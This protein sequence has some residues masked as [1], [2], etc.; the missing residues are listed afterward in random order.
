MRT[1]RHPGTP[2]A[3]RRH[4]AVPC[5]V[6]HHQDA[7]R[8]GT[9]LLQ[10]FD[11]LARQHAAHSAVARLQGGILSSMAYVMPALS[12]TPEHAV[13]YSDRHESARPVHLQTASV[14]L[15]RRN[16]EA[17]LHCHALWRDHTGRLAGGHLLAD[18]VIVHESPTAS[19][20]FMDGADFDVQ[21][22]TETNF[23]LFTPVRSAD[24]AFGKPAVPG[25]DTRRP[26]LAVS[27]RPNEDVCHALAAVCHEHGIERAH[28]H[29]GVGSLVGARLE[30]DVVVDPFV[31]EVLIED[32]HVDLSAPAG[33]QV[34]LDTAV[35]DYRGGL[36]RGR[37]LPGQNAV[38]VT[39]ELLLEPY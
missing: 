12:T 3:Q 8:P 7:L 22:C 11:D 19:L 30:P 24:T 28:V 5:F 2:I 10:A 6:R 38:L 32:G 20:W 34:C 1:I 36:T 39:F 31:T 18:D 27:L 13:F 23:S 21:A 29:G 33:R 35:I 17:W 26:A 4:T 14:T 9:P 25:D 37:L 16:G 15:G